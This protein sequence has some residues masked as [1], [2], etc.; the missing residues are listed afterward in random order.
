MAEKGIQFGNGADR[1]KIKRLP[2]TPQPNRSMSA[3]MHANILIIGAGVIGLTLARELTARGAKGVVVLDKEAESGKHASGRNSGVLHAGIYYTPDSLRAKTC[4][5]GNRLMREYCCEKS[6]PLLECGKVIVARDEGE[7]P[8]LDRL[9]TRATAN[10]AEAAMVDEAELGRIEPNA[11]TVGRALFSKHT[12]VIDPK[13]I[14]RALAADIEASGRGKL[15]YGASFTGLKNQT[16]AVTRA[17]EIT[18]DFCV[19]AS[20]AWSD[21]VA[22]HFGAGAGYRLLPFKGLYRKLRPEKSHLVRGNI[23]P[24]PDIRNPF[25]GVHFTKSVTG[26][27]YLGPTAIPALGRANYGILEG[28][29]AEVF[30]ILARD[31]Q[32]FFRDPLFRGI[33][34]SEPRKYAFK[35]FFEDAGKLVKE[36]APEDVINCSKA[37]IRP[38]LID[39]RKGGLVMDFVVERTERSL[40]V[41]NAISPAFTASMAFVKML[42]DEHNL[43]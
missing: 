17:G 25:L 37:G 19:N 30:A 27:V 8:T 42:A 35:H 34:L 32:L 9:F 29:D 6:L 13:A 23:Y 41:L 1:Q 7:W 28:L 43:A 38:Q 5:Q 40:H 3:P 33:A 20:G 2:F 11:K 36:L 22:A 18:F 16:T 26:D 12:A 31:L 24:V 21:K 15:L 10:E 14:L 4:I 39:I